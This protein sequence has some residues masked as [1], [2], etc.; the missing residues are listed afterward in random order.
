MIDTF[1]F[2]N[3]RLWIESVFDWP[4]SEKINF[5]IKSIAKHFAMPWK[6]SISSPKILLNLWEIAYDKS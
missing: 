6:I 1:L 5:A 3:E 4:I 2:R